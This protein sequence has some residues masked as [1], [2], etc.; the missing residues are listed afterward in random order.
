VGVV[1]YDFF[2]GGAAVV[3]LLC[4]AWA[5]LRHHPSPYPQS[6]IPLRPFRSSPP[7]TNVLLQS[8]SPPSRTSSSKI[9][10][11]NATCSNATCSNATCCSPS[12]PL[13]PHDPYIRTHST[14][15]ILS[16]PR[17]PLSFFKALLYEH[18][19]VSTT[20]HISSSHPSLA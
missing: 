8:C 9:T 15:Y 1:Y 12:L 3:R 18:A 4:A 17:T 19:L 14:S 7:W 2:Y 13:S 6:S 10:A 16:F 5:S 11:R 20:Y